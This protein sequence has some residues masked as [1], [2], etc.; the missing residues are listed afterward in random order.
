MTSPIVAQTIEDTD[1][2][3]AK[4]KYTSFTSTHSHYIQTP[5]TRLHY[6]Q[7]GNWDNPTI[8]WLHGSMSNAI[9]MEPF[10]KAITAQ[11]Y[12]LIAIDYYG[13][14]QTPIPTDSFSA[15][16]LLAD[17]N[18]LLDSLKIQTCII[19]GFSRGASFATLFYHYY[20][21]KVHALILEDGGVSPFLA[22]YTIL[23][24]SDLEKRF[25]A[26]ISDRPKELFEEY[27]TEKEAY[28]ALKQYGE[29]KR[30]QLYKNF[31]FIRPHNNKFV[32]Y[33]DTD[34]LYG[35]N[36]LDNI[37]ALAQGKLYSNPFANELMLFPYYNTIDQAN[38]PILL[39]EARSTS[40][41][42]PNSDD[43]EALKRN[44]P[45]TTHIVFR[46]SDHGIHYEEAKGFTKSIV[47]FL[48]KLK[49]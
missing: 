35:M 24:S 13:H 17:I 40:D 5:N 11:Q 18:T 42:Y 34:K 4:Q 15:Q 27:D 26:E 19:G 1:G 9:E 22:H 43:Y 14:G 12:N 47:K 33:K 49:K 20:P 32:I 7:W 10:A 21:E 2:R 3:E 45:N 44:N 36:T 23:S 25:N 37:T 38:I 8:I 48:N 16:S 29:S 41:P 30:S 46:K 31:S 6:L 28:T 39:L